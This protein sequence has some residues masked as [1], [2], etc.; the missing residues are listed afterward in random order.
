MAGLVFSRGSRTDTLTKPRPPV[1]ILKPLKGSDPGLYES[2]RSHC[3]QDYEEYEIICGASSRSDPAVG[4]VERLQREFP[5][6]RIQ[7]VIC[8]QRLGANGKISSLA[9]MVRNARHDVFVVSDSDI[10]VEP[11]YLVTVICELNQPEAGLVTCLYR[12]VPA[13]GF[14]SRIE[15]AG[16]S[17]DF[18][19]GVLA[20][21]I[22]ESGLKFGLGATL[23]LRREDLLNIGGFEALVDYLADDYELGRRIAEKKQKV[24]LSRS[25]VETFLP[26]YNWREF[27]THQLRWARTI[28]TAR[29]AG[30]AGLLITFTV[31][32]ALVAM[33]LSRGAD[34]AWTLLGLALLLR[35]V[36]GAVFGNL[37]L[38][39]KRVLRSLWLIPVRDLLGVVIWIGG[40][41]GNQIEWRG[42][43]FK[44]KRG[45]L[46]PIA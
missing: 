16:I 45:K 43:H 5:Q 29:P 30:Y 23:V 18:M 10:R 39:S 28:R 22:V 44:L 26:D 36:M 3:L 27:L 14:P 33:A 1:S 13:S 37:V 6:R 15:A 41:F 19:P 8:D 2:L 4:E 31:P 24:V 25:V 34:W 32:W 35:I 21:Q 38:G 40:W 12:G 9:Q 20:A 7:L 42:E 17:S 11:D 46:E